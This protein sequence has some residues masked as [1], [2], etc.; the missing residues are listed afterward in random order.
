MAYMIKEERMGVYYAGDRRT[1][2]GSRHYLWES[3]PEK[4]KHYRTFGSAQT[5]IIKNPM[6]ASGH[7]VYIVDDGGKRVGS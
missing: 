4:A 1:P 3:D 2:W 6:M 7:R 5:T